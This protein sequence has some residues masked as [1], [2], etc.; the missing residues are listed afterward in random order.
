MHWFMTE[1]GFGGILAAEG[2]PTFI[3]WSHLQRLPNQM[4]LLIGSFLPNH[5]LEKRLKFFSN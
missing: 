3:P 2:S 5:S 1:A 4:P